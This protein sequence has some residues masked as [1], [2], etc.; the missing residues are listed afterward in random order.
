MYI[1]RIVPLKNLSQDFLAVKW[2][3]LHASS[4]EGMGSTPSWRIKIPYA[5]WHGQKKKK[6]SNFVSI[7]F[8]F[9]D[10]K[11]SPILYTS[12]YYPTAQL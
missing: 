6:K 10:A 12:P 9:Q 1:M 2:L 7:M 4:A 11:H 3:R 5:S 8:L